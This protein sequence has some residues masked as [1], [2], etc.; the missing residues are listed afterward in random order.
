MLAWA[1]ESWI[2]SVTGDLLCPTGQNTVIGIPAMMGKWLL[3]LS[4]QGATPK[5][6]SAV[7]WFQGEGVRRCG[8]GGEIRLFCCYELIIAKQFT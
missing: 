8:V 5:I 7:K 4:F 2:S 3:I 1:K 6:L